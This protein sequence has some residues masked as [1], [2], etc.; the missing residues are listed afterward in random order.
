MYPQLYWRLWADAIIHVIH[1]RVL[2]HV[3][4]EAEARVLP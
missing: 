2:T 4:A 3:R 1:R